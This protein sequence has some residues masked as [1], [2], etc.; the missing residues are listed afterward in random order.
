MLADGYTVE[1][2]APVLGWHKP[3]VM[4]RR[5]IPELPETAQT[6]V[7]SGEIPVAG[8]DALLEIQAVSPTLAAL[9]S[10]S[11]AEGNQLG[12]QL[13][14]DAGWFVRQARSPTGLA[15]CSQPWPAAPLRGPDRRPQ[16]GQEDHRALRRGQD[17]A[18][19]ARPLRLRAA[20]GKDR[21]GRARPGRGGRR[22][23]GA[24]PH[25]GDRRPRRLPGAGQGCRGA[26]RRRS[27]R[28]RQRTRQPAPRPQGGEQAG[29]ARR[30]RTLTPSIAR[31]SGS[32]PA[33]PTPST[34]T[35]ARRCSTSLPPSTRRAWTWRASTAYTDV[36]IDE[37][38]GRRDY[39]EMVAERSGGARVGGLL[40]LAGAETSA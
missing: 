2:A 12:A 27:A 38:C 4:A 34:S 16:A 23:A 37:L 6:L 40:G 30:A 13:V 25:T 10:E 8:I 33:A 17:A 35:S 32:S 15:S 1:G 24:R 9:V 20:A 36:R 11:A 28:P 7:G 5:R 14:R 19:A 39:A 3:R 26:H 22:A 21:R 18:Q 29:S 31:S